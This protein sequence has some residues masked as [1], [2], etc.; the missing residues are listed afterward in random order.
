[1][2][3]HFEKKIRLKGPTL[4]HVCVHEGLPHASPQPQAGCQRLTGAPRT[5]SIRLPS[6]VRQVTEDL[7]MHYPLG[8]LCTSSFAL[9]TSLGRRNGK[10][11]CLYE[12]Y[13]HHALRAKAGKVGNQPRKRLRVAAKKLEVNRRHKVFVYSP[14]LVCWMKQY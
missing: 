6:G 10:Y 1:M 12:L 13:A 2:S 7:T 9:P 8:C 11:V 4:G 14:T 5:A 3:V